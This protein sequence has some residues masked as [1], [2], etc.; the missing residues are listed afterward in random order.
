MKLN[1]KLISIIMIIT[2]AVSA[3]SAQ[4]GADPNHDFYTDALQ[5]EIN[6]LVPRL[7]DVKP[8]PMTLIKTILQ[9]V[10]ESNDVAAAAKASVYYDSYFSSILKVGASVSAVSEI[11][12]NG[13]E[14]ELAGEIIPFLCLNSFFLD[15][16]SVSLQLSPML[17]TTTDDLLP[18]FRNVA[19]DYGNDTADIGP[20]K[21][22]T[23]LSAMT[24]YGSDKVYIQAGYS[25]IGFGNFLSD[26]VA[27]SSHAPQTGNVSFTINEDKWTYSLMALMLTATDDE[28]DNSSDKKYFYLHSLS[29]LPFPS[30]KVS[31]YESVI[32]GPRFDMIYMIPVSAFMVIQ[33]NIGMA[34][35]NLQLGMSFQYSVCKHVRLLFDFNADDMHFNDIIKLNLDT[36]MKFAAQ[37]GVQFAPES[38]N[39]L[40]MLQADY[41]MITPYTYTH[42]QNEDNETVVDNFAN[43]NYQNYT[44]RG[45]S[46]GTQLMPNSDRI[47]I[48]MKMEPVTLFTVNVN[49]SVIRHGNVN[50]NV[51]DETKLAYMKAKGRIDTTGTVF[52]FP[53]AG[54]GYLYSTDHFLFMSQQTKYYCIQNDLKLEYTWMFGGHQ[55]LSVYGA[56]TFQYERNKGIE[57]NIYTPVSSG[58]RGSLTDAEILARAASQ[59]QTWRDSLYDQTSNFLSFGVKYTY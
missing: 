2:L 51:N 17:K 38:S 8:Y 35:E 57:S 41:T 14:N 13:R 48:S 46:L 53:D 55:S 10:M 50:E 3:L 54:D 33:Q 42:S 12:D 20:L 28:G 37:V 40:K 23:S 21:V 22:R 1:R 7:P 11:T 59:L 15:K 9:T 29:F 32:T 43:A 45:K 30:L 6:G 27:V 25:R 24:S 18:A 58:E 26:S 39:L 31:I 5:W 49:T 36:R 4:I 56:W 47:S 19:M 44:T 52:D 34:N 16:G